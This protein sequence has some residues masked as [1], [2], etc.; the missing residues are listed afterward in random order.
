MYHHQSSY[1]SI[2]KSKISSIDKPNVIRVTGEGKVAV[3]PNK[4][5]VTL[6][7]STEDKQLMKAQED[8]ATKISKI[9]KT[10]NHLGIPDEQ[11]RTVNYSISPQ[12]DYVEGKQVFRGYKVEHLLLLTIDQIEHTGFVIDTAVSN[13]ANIVSMIK[14]AIADRNQYEQHAL[15]LAVINAYQKAETI[16]GTIRVQLTKA[17]ILITENIRQQGEP[18][19][20]QTTAFVKSEATTPIQPGTMEIISHITAEFVYHY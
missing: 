16:A 10:L 7:V 12:Y 13:G 18:I 14:F 2:P 20:F 17:P 15:S 3:Q 4:A 1:R 5:E 19:P 8:N 9:K 6:G 11:I